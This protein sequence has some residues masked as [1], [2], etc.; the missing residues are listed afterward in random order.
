MPAHPAGTFAPRRVVDDRQRVFNLVRKFRGQPAR[1][2]QPHFAHCKFPRFF[3][4]LPLPL[5][6][7]LDRITAKSHQ[8]QQRQ[9]QQQ[10]FS[11]TGARW[12]AVGRVAPNKALH[13]TIA[14]LAVTRTHH[15]PDATL[16]VVGKPGKSSRSAC[17]V[18][19]LA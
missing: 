9:A 6:Q 13:H 3:F 17:C 10:R 16:V 11:R 7:N 12:L 14:A 1:R 5:E 15:D 19:R 4:H 8:Q 18:R 2:S